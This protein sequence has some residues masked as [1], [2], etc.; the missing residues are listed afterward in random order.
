MRA[1]HQIPTPRPTMLTMN[2][3]MMPKRAPAHQPMPLVTVETSMT[4]SFLMY[5]GGASCGRVV[6]SCG[7]RG[8]S[9]AIG[10]YEQYAE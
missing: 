9:G 10:E 8:R 6:D 3:V 1:P 7:G 2:A 4:I 5:V